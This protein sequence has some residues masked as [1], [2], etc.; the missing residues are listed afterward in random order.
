[1]SDYM[2]EVIYLL[3][4]DRKRLPQLLLIFVAVSILDLVGISLVATYITVATSSQP[5]PDFMYALMEVIRVPTTPLSVLT[6][7]SGILL[8]LFLCKT[9]AG[10]AVSRE[11]INFATNQQVRLRCYLMGAYQS[12]PYEV[13]VSRNSSEYV[14]AMQTLVSQY[15]NKVVNTML[16]AISNGIVALLILALLA[17]Q[18]ILIFLLVVSLVVV[19]VIFYDLVFRRR[20]KRYGEIANTGATKVVQSLTEG[21]AGLKEI[22]ISQ[23]ENFFHQKVKESAELYSRYYALTA[24]I[25]AIPKYLIELIMVVFIVLTVLITTYVNTG[26]EQSVMSTL[27]L[28]GVAAIR[29]IPSINVISTAM[30]Q[31]SYNRDGVSRLYKDVRALEFEGV[32]GLPESHTGAAHS[33]E[34]S[35]GVF[36]SI[37][38]NNIVYA[39]PESKSNAINNVTISLR[40][41]E[42]IGLIGESGSGKSTLLDLLLALI[43]PS[44]GAILYNNR[45]LDNMLLNEWRSHVA[46][47]PQEVFLV[48]DTLKRNVALGLDDSEIC[49]ERVLEV[50]KKVKLDNLLE[51]LSKGID[52]SIG[53]GGMKLSGGQKQRLSLA[54]AFYHDKKVLVMDESTSSLDDKTEEKIVSEIQAL[55]GERTLIIIAHRLRAVKDCDRIYRLDNGQVIS[56]GTPQ[57]LIG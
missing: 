31:W 32:L 34:G 45:P 41:G 18:S 28:F 55:K 16:A 36:H 15:S 27:S 44:K 17:W 23:S 37:E 13:Y 24:I 47:L 42:S 8:A 3:G 26:G 25:G 56:V 12:L 39:Y 46:Y 30:V 50:L 6:A 35:D 33:T 19:V 57:E 1:M 14:F 10:I 54:R 29:L 48:D 21:I 40:R 11:I 5:I 52:S 51:S 2:K 20:A 7:L 53:E 38:L 22:R 49:E 9:V 4:P 43:P